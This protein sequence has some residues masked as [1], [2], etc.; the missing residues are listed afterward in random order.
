MHQNQI[1]VTVADEWQSKE[2][3]TI[4]TKMIESARNSGVKQLYSIDLADNPAM[5]ALARQSGMI[6]TPDPSDRHQ[7]IHS[8]KL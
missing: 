6:S 2:F 8:L 7:I 4:L 5:S 1:T 3:C